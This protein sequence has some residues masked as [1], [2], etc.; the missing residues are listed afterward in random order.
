MTEEEKSKATA[1]HGKIATWLQGLGV[2]ANWAKVGA[3]VVVGAAAGALAT[4]QQSCTN[5]P[6]PTAAQIQAAHTIFHVVTGEKCV[7]ERTEK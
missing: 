1:A 3:G 5:V 2:P 6:A 4:C 7:I